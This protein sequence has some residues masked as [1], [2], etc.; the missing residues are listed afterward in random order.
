MDIKELEAV[1]KTLCE[2]SE[3]PSITIQFRALG[4]LQAEGGERCWHVH[5]NGTI[6]QANN[7]VHALGQAAVGAHEEAEAALKQLQQRS[8]VNERLTKGARALSIELQ[9]R[10]K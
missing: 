1:L 10:D 7:L 2:V 5:A 6:Y 4:P 8:Q 3:R 9:G